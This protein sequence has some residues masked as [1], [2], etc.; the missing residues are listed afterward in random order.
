MGLRAQGTIPLGPLRPLHPQRSPPPR[1]PSHWLSRRSMEWSRLAGW[2]VERFR[3][4]GGT[5]ELIRS[6]PTD[7]RRAEQLING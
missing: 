4:A 2:W 1:V 5:V 7:S 6:D 3:S